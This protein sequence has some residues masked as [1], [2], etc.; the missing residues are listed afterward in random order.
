MNFAKENA[1]LHSA[2]ELS[3]TFSNTQAQKGR[4]LVFTLVVITRLM[5]MSQEVRRIDSPTTK[6][7]T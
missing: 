1:S 4:I 6:I 5:A 3:K 2:P 7:C